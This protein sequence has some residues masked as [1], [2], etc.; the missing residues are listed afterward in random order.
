MFAS[1]LL[2]TSF[3][4]GVLA[5]LIYEDGTTRIRQH[6][7]DARLS[8]IRCIGR[9]H[10]E[11]MSMSAQMAVATGEAEWRDRFRE[12]FDALRD[13]LD[14]GRSGRGLVSRAA[15]ARLQQAVERAGV[16]LERAL[17]TG[18]GERVAGLL[19]DLDAAGTLLDRVHSDLSVNRFERL[20]QVTGDILRYDEQRTMSTRLAA[21]T[22]DRHWEAS[23]RSSASRLD[24]SIRQAATLVTDDDVRREAIAPLEA[25]NA[26]LASWDDLAFRD[27]RHGQREAVAKIFSYPTYIRH[28][29]IQ[30]E[31]VER[32]TQHLRRRVSAE[33]QER[34]EPQRQQMLFVALALAILLALWVLVSRSIRAWQKAL[35]DAVA[36]SQQAEH[37]VREA[38]ERLEQRVAERTAALLAAQEEQRAL[39]QQLAKA[40]RLESIGRLAGGLSHDFNNLL[41]VVHGHAELIQLASPT[42]SEVHGSAGEIIDT[43]GRAT[44]L[45]R[46]LLAFSRRQVMSP[47]NID[48]NQLVDNLRR[49]LDRLLS[50]DVRLEVDPAPELPPVLADPAQIERVLMNLVANACDAMPE[51]G[52]IR[53]ETRRIPTGREVRLNMNDVPPLPDRPLVVMSVSD[54]GSGMTPEVVARA[55]EPFFTTKGEGRGTGLGLSTVYGIVKQSGGFIDIASNVG[56]GSTFVLY[57]PA[58]SGPCE[59]AAAPDRRQYV[60]SAPTNGCV[61]VA[62]DQDDVRRFV[63]RLLRRSGLTVLEAASGTEALDLVR[64][65]QPRVSV[66]LTDMVMPGMKGPVLARLLRQR[67]PKLHVIFMSGYASEELRAQGADLAEGILLQ[68]PVSAA[69][70]LRAVEEGMRIA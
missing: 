30:A 68:K 53:I 61:L 12:H 51:G 40:E 39:Q 15:V 25:A 24:E 41:T 21:V 9:Y 55:F 67:L 66:L 58:A 56:E 60:S 49:I 48:L 27:M 42:E 22:G 47:R 14:L 16:R 43:C 38:R 33:G 2:V 31:A 13:I 57:F 17:A 32:L 29:R 69:E 44:A 65:Q 63:V 54:S 70:L 8:E 46:Q 59:P 64:D 10:L 5:Y 62:E 6:S 45:T 20:M 3:V 1:A 34:I 4:L 50:V 52:T 18:D 28:R 7:T 23:Y 26:V 11:A 37:E 19:S 35:S 36:R